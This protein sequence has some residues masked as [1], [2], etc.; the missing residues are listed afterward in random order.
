MDIMSFVQD[1]KDYIGC[2]L[3]I[4]IG[5]NTGSCF[6]GVIGFNKPQFSLIGD[7]VNT[8]S[9]VCS[10]GDIG[11]IMLSESSFDNLKGFVLDS[12]YVILPK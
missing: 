1:S 7:T 10:T 4:K 2:S 11:H 5:I 12:H 6:M 8:A 9:W 3:K